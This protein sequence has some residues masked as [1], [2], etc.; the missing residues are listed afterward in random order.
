MENS[1]RRI[2]NRTNLDIVDLPFVGYREGDLALFEYT[3]TD[4]SGSGVQIATRL[5]EGATVR[6]C[7]KDDV[8]R[9]LL[10][11]RSD[12][13][14]NRL[15]DQGRIMWTREGTSP[16]AVVCGL[17]LETSEEEAAAKGDS[18][19]PRRLS[20]S[21]ETS[22]MAFEDMKTDS[23]HDFLLDVLRESVAA[24]EGLLRSLRTRQ[25]MR[26]RGGSWIGTCPGERQ[27]GIRKGY[28]SSPVI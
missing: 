9:L 22:N 25:C 28:R 11:L 12:G 10:F 2:G 26:E 5:R 18:G 15:F 24:K 1:D 14:E 27:D 4:V 7:G 20:L 3:L 21:L 13:E 23:A 16:D 17:H 6:P 19:I 8:V